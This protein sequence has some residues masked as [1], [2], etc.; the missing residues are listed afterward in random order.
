MSVEA[1]TWAFGQS[2]PA[3]Q[4]IVLLAIANGCNRDGYGFP[5]L[6]GLVEACAPMGRRMVQRHIRQLEAVCLVHREERFLNYGKQTSN[7]YQLGMPGVDTTGWGRGVQSDTLPQRGEGVQSDTLRVSQLCH[8][9]GVTAMT[10]SNRIL[11]RLINQIDEGSRDADKPARPSCV[12][13]GT[14]SRTERTPFPD[15]WPEAPWM[16]EFCQ[17]RGCRYDEEF[18]TFSAHHKA[19]GSR[20]AS[21]PDAFRK[22]VMNSVRFR[23]RDRPEGQSRAP[24]MPVTPRRRAVGEPMPEDVRALVGLATQSMAMEGSG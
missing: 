8:P 9:E 13:R 1:M 21:W 2:L 14:K 7:G 12:P 20:F 24:T 17:K 16:Q 18:E 4:K 5:S 23:Q 10:P 11:T 3:A 19:E 22:W 6:D 15:P